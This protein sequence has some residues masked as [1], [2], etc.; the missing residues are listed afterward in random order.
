MT[1]HLM[2]INEEEG[3]IGFQYKLDGVHH[4]YEYLQYEKYNDNDTTQNQEATKAS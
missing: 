1:R 3:W 4:H 2:W